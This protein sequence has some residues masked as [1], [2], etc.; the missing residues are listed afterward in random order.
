MSIGKNIMM[1]RK[2]HNITATEFSELLGISKST[3]S[4]YEHNKR[5]PD[6]ET[7]KAMARHLN[8][9]L[10]YLLDGDNLM[11]YEENESSLTIAEEYDEDELIIED[12][13]TPIPQSINNIHQ[14]FGEQCCP[15]DV[16]WCKLCYYKDFFGHIEETLTSS[17]LFRLFLKKQFNY[18][19]SDNIDELYEFALTM[20]NL[21][22]TEFKYIEQ[23][24]ALEKEVKEKSDKIIKQLTSK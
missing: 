10:I 14:H 24:K 7:F 17:E 13:D 19:N 12:D 9:P 3:L 1:I 21:K 11:S 5:V 15:E 6:L 23:Q 2:Y 18:L 16:D 20:I 4:R 8:V 22:I